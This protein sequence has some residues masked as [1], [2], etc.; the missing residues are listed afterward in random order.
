LVFYKN[1]IKDAKIHVK[2]YTVCNAFLL[3]PFVVRCRGGGKLQAGFT[4]SLSR[5][6]HRDKHNCEHLQ[7]M[8]MQASISMTTDGFP[9]FFRGVASGEGG[10]VFHKSRNVY[11]YC[12]I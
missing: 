3:C 8:L 4:A 2:M 10:N 5:R 9:S 1:Y 6:C 12:E 7:C 11:M